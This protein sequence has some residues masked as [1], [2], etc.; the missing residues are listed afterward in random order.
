M[1]PST[2]YWAAGIFL[3]YQAYRGWRLGPV[4][5]LIRIGA[6]AAAYITGYFMG[7]SI[8]PLLSFTGFPNFI[9]APLGGLVVGLV[10]YAI[11]LFVGSVLFKKTSDQEYGLTWLI[12]GISGSLLGFTLGLIF[13][14]M[15][16]IGLQI[17]GTLATGLVSNPTAAPPIR[18]GN[19]EEIA[20]S[21]TSTPSSASYRIAALKDTL[22]KA[23]PG[24]ALKNFD[25]VPEHTYVL[26]NKLG[27]AVSSPLAL[28]RFATYPGVQ[29]LATRPEIIA[30]RDDPEIA[31]AVRNYR[32][33]QLLRHPRIVKTA[34]DPKLGEQLR[35]FDVEKALDYAIG[36][37]SAPTTATPPAPYPPHAPPAAPH[38]RP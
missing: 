4:R 1:N 20:G 26:L 9:L 2:L 21:N 25:P 7:G 33:F 14:F 3:T 15:F 24:N 38:P 27:K 37:P 11:V 6:L 13:L 16:T 23:F 31:E 17:V 12:Y 30:L 36:T 34:N 8:A 18:E 5:L 28:S 35:K 22:D 10:A 32:Y 29:E 19:N